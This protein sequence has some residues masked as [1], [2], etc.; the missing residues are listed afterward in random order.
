M[1]DALLMHAHVSVLEMLHALPAA[2]TV[3]KECPRS[4]GEL[5]ESGVV[6]PAGQGHA[7]NGFGVGAGAGWHKD[8]PAAPRA[9]APWWAGPAIRRD[10]RH[11]RSALPRPGW[12]GCRVTL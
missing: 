2:P 12:G 5:L 9:P 1:D 10:A 4:A 7:G 8:N 6:G 11:G 3:R